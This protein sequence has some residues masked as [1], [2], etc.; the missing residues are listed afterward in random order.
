MT[1]DERATSRRSRTAAA[2]HDRLLEI[3]SRRRLFGRRGGSQGRLG[4]ERG[5]K[6]KRFDRDLIAALLGETRDARDDVVNSLEYFGGGRNQRSSSPLAPTPS[7][8]TFW[9]SRTAVEMRRIVPFGEIVCFT[10]RLGW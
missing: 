2:H 3:E 8:R 1:E 5:F 4:L 10:V 6:G 9:S 7:Q